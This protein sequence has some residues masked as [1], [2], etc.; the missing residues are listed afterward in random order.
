MKKILIVDVPDKYDLRV[1]LFDVKLK[2]KSGSPK[3]LNL[4]VTEF[5]PPSDEEITKQYHSNPEHGEITKAYVKGW[6]SGMAHFKSL[7]T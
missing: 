3:P 2:F 1:A 7:L 4:Y 6:V 5:I